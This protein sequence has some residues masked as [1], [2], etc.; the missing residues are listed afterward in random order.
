[1]KRRTFLRASSAGVG[2]FSLSAWG[3]RSAGEESQASRDSFQYVVNER[4]LVFDHDSVAFELDPGDHRIRVLGD[5]GK[6]LAEAGQQPFN[7]INYPH[8]GATDASGRM[9]FLEGGAPGIGVIEAATGTVKR[10][11]QA[12]GE[13]K[14]PT[15][16]ALHENGQ[17]YVCD[18]GDHCVA[19]FD[20]KG[21]RQ[22]EFGKGNF[23][24]E[25][26]LN[27]P[28]GLAI[29][30]AGQVHVVDAGNARVVVFGP[31]GGFKR[32]YGRFGDGEGEFH[33]PRAIAI[34]AGRVCVADPSTGYVSIFGEDGTFRRRF[35]P[36]HESDGS[37]AAPLEMSFDHDGVLQ[38]W[39]D[40]Q[41]SHH[42]AN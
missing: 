3:C 21:N 26:A 38:I 15:D 32:S 35:I 11:A 2:L 37:P 20:K 7:G 8:A 27:G 36:V 16:I 1:M 13:M 4:H 42:A 39:S 19:V 31:K 17:L 18:T 10:S 12:A 33:F 22:A 28:R 14:N 41:R 5:R 24:D 25:R 30:S 40:G 23:G 34:H 29:D 6:T 9:F